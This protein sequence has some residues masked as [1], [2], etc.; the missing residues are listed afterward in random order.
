MTILEESGWTE[1]KNTEDFPGAFPNWWLLFEMRAAAS[2]QIY[3]ESMCSA[4]LLYI[5]AN[6][7]YEESQVK[8][9]SISKAAISNSIFTDSPLLKT[10]WNKVCFSQRKTIFSIVTRENYLN[11]GVCLMG[12]LNRRII[13]QLYFY[14]RFFIRPSFWDS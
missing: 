10:K 2:F 4:E 8:V 13:F 14:Y 5:V 6:C 1:Q 7:I 3:N 12:K 9:F 11:T